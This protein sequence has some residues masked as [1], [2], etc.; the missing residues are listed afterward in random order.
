MKI[1]FLSTSDSSGGAAIACLRLV[2]ALRSE[3]HE[4]KVLVMEKRRPDDWIQAAPDAWPRLSTA[5]K[6]LS[7]L[8]QQKFVTQSGYQY[9]GILESS[10]AVANHPWVVEADVFC[11]HWV[12]HGFIDEGALRL[13]F[14]LRK[15]V[16]WHMHDFWAF[17]GGC[18]YPGKCSEFE[19]SCRDCA[20]LKPIFKAAA[21]RKLRERLK[22]FE[23][24]PPVLVGASQ[25]LANEAQKSALAKVSTVVHVPNP[26]DPE[27]VPMDKKRC[28][29]ELKLNPNKRYLLFAAMNV[30]DVRKGFHLLKEALNE[31][32]PE[33]VG[34]L[35]AGKF[36]PEHFGEIALEVRAMGRLNKAGMMRAY[37]AADLFVIP[38]LEENLPNT[39]L[40]SLSCGTPVAGFSIGGIPEMVNNGTNGFLSD[41]LTANGLARA[42]EAGL[43]LVEKGS[44]TAIRCTLSVERFEPASI[45][46][47]YSKLIRTTA[48]Y[49]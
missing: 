39:V 4:A 3:G 25:W 31:L 29:E 46:K 2:E 10:L 38:S 1:L 45:A 34:C 24:N 21:W 13:L 27:F 28:R 12:N 18:H 9:T 14:S 43:A 22:T 42:I 23:L 19:R 16:F 17:T 5:K 6:H 47:Q 40:E 26:L 7:Y 33:S 35:V 36:K 8:L 41:K 49:L 44:E 32:D 15:P 48:G 37:N 11:L 30:A 20:A